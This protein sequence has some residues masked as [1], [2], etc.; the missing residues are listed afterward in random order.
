MAEK[1]DIDPRT[2]RKYESGESSPTLKSLA[3]V[4]EILE[5]NLLSLIGFSPSQ[6]FNNGQYQG[7]FTH[8]KFD[9]LEAMMS[10]HQSIVVLKDEVI[11]SL[12]DEIQILKDENA[13]LKE[14]SRR[15]N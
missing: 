10:L 12:R 7:N 13:L 15:H 4:A 9:N 11:A 14:F 1:L 2:Y 5:M 3:K 6:I 8:N